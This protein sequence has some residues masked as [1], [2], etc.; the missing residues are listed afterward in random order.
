MVQYTDHQSAS[1]N[2]RRKCVQLSETLPGHIKTQSYGLEEMPIC[3][4]SSGSFSALQPKITRHKSTLP[5]STQYLTLKGGR[6][7]YSRDQH[8]GHLHYKPP[9]LLNR[10]ILYLGLS[11]PD[12][13]MIDTNIVPSRQR[14][15]Q[16][17]Y[18]FMEESQH[19]KDGRGS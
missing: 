17:S 14:P 13:I 9:S 18:S 6:L 3:P 15:F 8:R 19:T 10:C 1:Q 2:T 5:L 16:T 11:D 12:I 4:I 7:P